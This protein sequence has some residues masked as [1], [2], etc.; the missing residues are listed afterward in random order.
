MQD[1]YHYVSRRTELGF[2]G[3]L[4]NAVLGL[5]GLNLLPVHDCI[6]TS[7]GE[8]SEGFEGRVMNAVLGLIGLNLLPVH[9]CII[10]SVGEQSEGFEGR[11]MNAVLG[12]KGLKLL[13][14]G[15]DAACTTASLRH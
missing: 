8:Q 10:T 13:P 15:G 9:D 12:L 14:R 7:V 6:I 1:L 11:L 3:R 4:M 2:E 5:K